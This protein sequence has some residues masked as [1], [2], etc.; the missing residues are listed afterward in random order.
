M[1]SNRSNSR[2][3]TAAAAT[4]IFHAALIAV[5]LTIFL[6]Y[7]GGEKVTREWPPVDSSEILFGGEYVMIGDT[8]EAAA[9]E[10][11]DNQVAEPVVDEPTPTEPQ[12][13]LLTQ[14]VKPAP[15]AVKTPKAAEEKPKQVEEKPKPKAADDDAKRQAATNISNRVKFGEA[16]G[17]TGSP[18]GNASTGAVSG[19]ASSGLG[20]R[21]AVELPRPAR[22]PLGK[23]VISIKVNR[24]GRVTAASF[25][26]GEGAAAADAAT[27]QRCIAAAKGARFTPSADAP[28]SQNGTLTYTFK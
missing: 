27:R 16:K 26:T 14:T 21:A 19:V 24:D 6:K 20:N 13:Q 10:Q 23:I 11:A 7:D 25:L 4:L 2:R 12:E 1:S 15:E 5:L 17:S 28:A 9:G 22:S 8:P 3:A 18:D